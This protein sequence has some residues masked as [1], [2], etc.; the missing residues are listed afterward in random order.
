M[1]EGAWGASQNLGEFSDPVRKRLCK[2]KSEP[3]TKDPS[4]L[5]KK[6]KEL[7]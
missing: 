2:I 4:E 5:K 1:G 7:N 6:E 3:T